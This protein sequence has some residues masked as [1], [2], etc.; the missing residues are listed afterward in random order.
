[1][2]EIKT[3]A[4]EP[5][6]FDLLLSGHTHQPCNGRYVFNGE[7]N[8][9]PKYQKQDSHIKVFWTGGTWDVYYGGYSPEATADTPV[10][11]LT[12]YTRD[13]GDCNIVVSYE[14]CSKP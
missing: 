6:K 3:V 14:H 1:M 12:G 8:G 4:K 9:K 11:P 2:V 5:S 10:P 13:Q 7:E